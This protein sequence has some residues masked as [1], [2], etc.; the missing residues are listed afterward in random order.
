MNR[1]R[2]FETPPRRAQILLVEDD[3]GD[4]LLTRESLAR[5]AVPC[6]VSVVDDGDVALDFLHKR[7]AYVDAPTPDLVL[8]DL[9]LP[10]VGGH[11]VLAEVKAHPT[12]ATIPVVVLSTSDAEADIVATYRLH[13]NAYVTKPVDL[14]A[15]DRVVRGID[16]FFLT[17]A[18][19]PT[20]S[21]WG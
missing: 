2:A 12:L 6:E 17:V 19:L 4:V 15:Y 18:R 9:N 3:P 5:S 11:E 1:S 10:K 16:R 13:A 14:D 21:G 20:G 8:L 7:L